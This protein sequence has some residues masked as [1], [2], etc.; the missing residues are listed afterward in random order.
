ME[1]AS[2]RNP[3]DSQIAEIIA[4]SEHKAVKWIKDLGSGDIYYW[5]AERAFHRQVAESLSIKV[6][7]KGLAIDD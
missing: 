5:E 2:V 1:T 3:T 6:F 4:R 7:E